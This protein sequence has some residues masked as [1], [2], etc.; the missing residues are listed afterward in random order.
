[1]CGIFGIVYYEDGKEINSSSLMEV[2]AKKSDHRGGDATGFAWNRK[3][4]I[5]ISKSPGDAKVFKY[6]SLYNA[7]CMMGHVRY[8]T[9]GKAAKN[10]NNHPFIGRTLEGMPF[11][12][13]HNG[14]LFNPLIEKSSIETDTY[15]AVQL[16][17]KCDTI[18][19]KSIAE[20]CEK[21]EGS[22]LFTILDKTGIY[23][24]KNTSPCIVAHFPGLKLWIYASEKAIINNTIKEFENFE[25][26]KALYTE[27]G[28]GD[29]FHISTKGDLTKACFEPNYT[30]TKGSYCTS[31]AWDDSDEYFL[32]KIEE[33][34]YSN[35]L[36]EIS[37][38]EALLQIEDIIFE[39]YQ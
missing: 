27:M 10:E 6:S 23:L 16:L 19:F 32:E 7:K 20:S 3:N 34:I 37:A 22:F 26:E 17:E 21:I 11:A 1:M 8:A 4:K 9:Q 29:I 31:Y 2:L 39:R 28:E 18:D 12:L 13:A 14:I 36:E 30:Y 25:G 33:V 38:K 24:A 35:Q 15:L 5:K